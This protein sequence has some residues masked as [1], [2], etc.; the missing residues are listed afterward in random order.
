MQNLRWMQRNRDAFPTES[1]GSVT[2]W[3]ISFKA[4]LG[5]SGLGLKHPENLH[6]ALS[7][8]P[9][10]LPVF[11][12]S[13]VLEVLFDR[14]PT[15]L[16]STVKPLQA[17]SSRHDFWLLTQ[18]WLTMGTQVG[19]KGKVTPL[20]YGLPL[21]CYVNVTLLVRGKCVL[22]QL[23]QIIWNF[24]NFTQRNTIKKSNIC[25]NPITHK[26][27]SYY[28]SSLLAVAFLVTSQWNCS[29]PLLN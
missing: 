14:T 10:K 7:M 13:A 29:Q 11:A 5:V 20:A 1:E 26:N 22:R 8:R 16:H 3:T 15:T 19:G 4:V 24:H 6:I 2:P 25:I 12:C 18:H 21:D 17:A 27:Y 28:L 9:Y 23:W